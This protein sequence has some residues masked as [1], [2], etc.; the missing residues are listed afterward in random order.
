MINENHRRVL[1]VAPLGRDAQL[2]CEML[3]NNR[4]PC[5]ACADV[6]QLCE[7]VRLGVGVV[8]LTEE[9]LRSGENLHLFKALD[10]QPYWSDLPVILLIGNARRIAIEND[11]AFGKNGPRGSLVILEKPIRPQSLRTAVN[12]ALATRMRQYEVQNYLRERQLAEA[13]LRE[14]EERYRLLIEGVRDHAIYMLDAGGHVTTWN[15]GAERLKGYRSEEIIGEHVSRFYCAEDIE[16]GKPE[17]D[18]R[19]AVERGH[20]EDEGWAIRKDGTR[21]FADFAISALTDEA[22]QLRG[23]SKV[24]RDIT[25]RKRAE[26]ALRTVQTELAH[27]S[28]VSMAGELSTSIAHQLNQPL[29]AIVTNGDACLRW[30]GGEVKYLDEARSAVQRMVDSAMHAASV[31]KALRSFVSKKVSGEKETLD[32]N[33]MIRQ[34]LQFLGDELD[35]NRITL[36]MELHPSPSKIIGDRVQLQ[37]V[38]LNLIL[39]SMEA[40]TTADSS[41]RKLLIRSE[42][43]D[44]GEVSICV[45]DSGP[46]ITTQNAKRLFDPF[47]STKKDGLGLGLSISRT[48]IEAHGGKLWAA[49]RQDAGA[50][51][52]FTL[53]AQNQ[54]RA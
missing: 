52:Q 43:S 5:A 33:E 18:L 9:A 14:A 42:Q 16:R 34:V 8:L 25:E 28:R 31:I 39:N 3:G 17:S 50:I 41:V 49:G 37:Q 36:Q 12:A 32:V 54:S 48:I 45:H 1:V 47:F 20:F 38:L 10:E 30:L 15:Q 46:G 13:I 51:F 44:S 22:G 6:Q 4:I 27:A 29:T 24:T 23:F 11:P 53:P 21:F 7:E 26:D 2:L 19:M 40:M 35:R